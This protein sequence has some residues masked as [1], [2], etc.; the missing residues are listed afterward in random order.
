VAGRDL[1]DAGLV[2]SNSGNMSVRRAGGIVITRHDSTLASLE[3]GD[4]IEVARGVSSH[5]LASVELVVHQAIYEATPALAVVHAHPP[6][7]I[8]LSLAL[9]SNR[10]DPVD[11]VVGAVPI[12]EAEALSGSEALAE[13]MR[14]TLREHKIALAR[15]HGSFAI[16]ETLAEAC[17]LT[18]RLEER[19]HGLLASRRRV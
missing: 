11:S 6:A 18:L 10:I 15:G 5:P 12:I 17:E 8:A 9:A 14:E 19:C 7:A 4:L 16:G 13:A 2:S 1:S 3:E